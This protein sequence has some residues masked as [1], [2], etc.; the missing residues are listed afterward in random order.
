MKQFETAEYLR[1]KIFLETL[2]RF[3][4]YKRVI[5]QGIDTYSRENELARELF[6]VLYSLLE[7][8][9]YEGQYQ[10]WKNKVLAAAD[11]RPDGM[12]K[13]CEVEWSEIYSAIVD[14]EEEKEEE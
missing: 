13:L 3:Y 10:A 7:D 8:T 11:V 14:A 4:R 12:K 5:S 2:Y 6:C 9:G 1:D